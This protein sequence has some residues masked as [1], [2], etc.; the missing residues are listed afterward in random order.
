MS[1]SPLLIPSFLC[2]I[3]DTPRPQDWWQVDDNDEQKISSSTSPKRS[4]KHG[5]S[6]DA[7][8]SPKSNANLLVVEGSANNG[9]NNGDVA[10]QQCQ[11]DKNKFKNIGYENWQKSRAEWCVKTVDNPKRAPPVDSVDEVE[12]KTGL[13]QVQRTFEL[14]VRVSLPNIIGLYQSIWQGDD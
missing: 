6:S 10:M 8:D 13:S 12:I 9:N 1:L 4:E 3:E 5:K 2:L 11:K 7:G 14:P